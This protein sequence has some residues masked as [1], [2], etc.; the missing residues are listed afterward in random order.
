MPMLA[1][2]FSGLAGLLLG[3]VVITCLPGILMI[4][5]GQLVG[6]RS[7]TILLVLGLTCIGAA[8]SF[9]VT[10]WS[11]ERFDARPIYLTPLFF[12]VFLSIGAWRSQRR[13]RE[14][15]RER[16]GLCRTC[17]YDL[18]ATPHRCPECGR[19]AERFQSR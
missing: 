4:G 6:G 2:D 5:I 1:S 9:L 8:I 10:F 12:L 7:R 14:R 18:R 3:F 11:G 13:A 16:N 17:G 19:Y 15:E